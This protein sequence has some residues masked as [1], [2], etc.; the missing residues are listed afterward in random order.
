MVEIKILSDLKQPQ[1][2]YL[3]HQIPDNILNANSSV[4]SIDNYIKQL[5]EQGYMHNHVRMYVASITCNVAKA[6]WL[7]PANWLYYHLLDGDVASNHLSWQWVCGSASSKK[8]YCN[9]ENINRYTGSNQQQSFLAVDYDALTEM[10][11][12]NELKKT[13]TIN[14]QTILPTTAYLNIDSRKPTCI[15]NSYNL[16]AFWRKNEDVNRVLLLEPSHFKKHPV[17]KK[18]LDFIIDLSKNIDGIFI[19]VGEFE[20]FNNAY[21]DTKTNL[22]F[23]EHPAFNHYSGICDEREW[24]S[25]NVSGNYNSFSSFWKKLEKSKGLL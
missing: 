11:V 9:Q 10:A 18:V 20:D 1:P 22:I 8:Y 23:K 19:Y 21:P 16:D 7:A 4:V 6:H 17:S 5:Y 2:D 24:I 12:P 15:Y 13:S 3:Q 14:L 25:E